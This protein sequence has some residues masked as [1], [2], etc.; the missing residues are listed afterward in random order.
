MSLIIIPVGNLAFLKSISQKSVSLNTVRSVLFHAGVQ[1]NLQFWRNYSFTTTRHCVITSE[2]RSPLDS[3]REANS[4]DQSRKTPGVTA[5]SSDAERWGSLM[6]KK[7][8]SLFIWCL[9][10]NICR[11][12]SAERV[13]RDSDSCLCTFV[14]S[15]PAAKIHFAPACA[16]AASPRSHSYRTWLAHQGHRENSPGPVWFIW[17][18]RAAAYSPRWV[19]MHRGCCSWAACS[20]SPLTEPCSVGDVIMFRLQPII[21]VQLVK[22]MQSVGDKTDNGKSKGGAEKAEMSKKKKKKESSINRRE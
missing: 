2:S 19:I 15:L 8:K 3:S 16:I 7:K 9:Q 1:I 11:L 17:A 13:G 12:I 21:T 20:P 18:T 10:G 22:A 5:L 14:S 4:L 6:V